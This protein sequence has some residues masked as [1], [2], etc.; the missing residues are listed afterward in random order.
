[1]S[2]KRTVNPV[3]STPDLDATRDSKGN[4]QKAKLARSGAPKPEVEVVE[5]IAQNSGM[6]MAMKRLTDILTPYL[7]EGTIDVSCY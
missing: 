3:V 6:K 1:M 7:V 4:V 2:E 5:I